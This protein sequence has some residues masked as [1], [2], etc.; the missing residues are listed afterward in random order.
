MRLLIAGGGTGGHLYPGIAVAR[1]WLRGGP[2]HRVLFVG[3]ARGIEARVLPREGLPLETIAAAGVIGRSAGQKVGAAVLMVRG[4]A[5]SLGI[6][7]RFQPHVVLGVGG[8]TSAPAVAAAWL[9]RRPIVLMEQNAVPGVANRLLGRLAYRVAVSLPG[10]IPHFPTGMTVQTGLP[11]REGF[12]GEPERPASFWE[13]PLR[14]LV[15]GGSQGAHAL[16]EAV[17]E[18]LPLLGEDARRMRFVHQTGEAGL[19]RMRAA[20]AGAGAEA[21]VAAFFYDM[22]D[23]FRWAHLAVARAGAATVAELTAMGL[24]AVLVP[25]PS[26]T[27]GHQEANARFLEEGG[28]VRMVLQRELSGARLAALLREFEASRHLLAEMSRRSRDLARPDASEAVAAL[29]REAARAA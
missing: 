17:A 6:I 13:G 21:E 24:P 11:L 10:A 26:A 9:R 20:Y 22:A 27:H 16:N 15:F 3:T 5:Q 25:F 1:A 7:G 2:D 19:E 14:V 28:A 8:Y 18:A 23:R 12:A 4:L 29:C